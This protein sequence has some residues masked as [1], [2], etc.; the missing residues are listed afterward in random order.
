MSLGSDLG[1][2]SF[3][4]VECAKARSILN[5]NIAACYL[6]LVKDRASDFD[7]K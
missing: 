4:D 2:W 3:L 1:G 6:K 5:G 7:F